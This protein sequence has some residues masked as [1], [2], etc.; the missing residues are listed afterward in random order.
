MKG[1]AG[2]ETLLAAQPTTQ[3]F[4]QMFAEGD[5]GHHTI[6][7]MKTNGG[8]GPATCANC[9]TAGAGQGGGL[10]GAKPSYGN[11][12]KITPQAFQLLFEFGLDIIRRRNS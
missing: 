2:S 5:E 4:T 12:S 8:N 11:A 3:S 1:T 9:A 7:G 10:S 6:S